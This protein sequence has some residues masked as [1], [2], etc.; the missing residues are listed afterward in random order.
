[1]AT[2]INAA[3][4]SIGMDITKLKEGMGATSSELKK[5]G[6]LLRETEDPANKFR[7]EMELMNRALESGGITMDQYSA[8]QEKL[9]AK[10][11]VVTPAM[12]RAAEA[13]AKLAAE[14][15]AAAEAQRVA[16]EAEKAAMQ[17][18]RDRQA[19]L[20]RGKQLTDS[21]RTATEIHT[22]KI[23]EYKS[24]LKSGLITQETYNRLIRE[25]NSDL[26]K[27]ESQT[28]QLTAAIK[29]QQAET[30]QGPGIS[31]LLSGQL[32]KIAGIAGGAFTVSKIFGDVEKLDSINDKAEQLGIS[33]KDLLVVGRTFEETGGLSFDQA[34]QALSKM[35]VNL[36]NARDKGGDLEI[37]LK[38]V[39]LSSRELAN[40][41]AVTAFQKINQS[42]SQIGNQ[43]DKMQ[44]A[45][46]LFGKAGIDM[47]PA[48]SISAEKFSEMRQHLESVGLL[49]DDLPG[50][51]SKTSDEIQ[52]MNDILLGA[53][54]EIV[55]FFE[56]VFD[57]VKSLT[58]LA[59]NLRRI[60]A[61]ETI[62]NDVAGVNE[63][64][65]KFNTNEIANM[66]K[67][68]REAFENE[69]AKRLADWHRQ[70]KQTE[71]KAAKEKEVQE[72]MDKLV[73]R[74]DAQILKRK[75]EAKQREKEQAAE[76]EKN[77]KL[78]NQ[79]D[80]NLARG[81]E[82]DMGGLESERQ[83]LLGAGNQNVAATIA[84]AIRA[85]TVEAYKA[86]NKQNE[87]RVARQENI[88]KLDEIKTELQKLNTER[89]VILSRI[90]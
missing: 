66:T 90:R 25:A 47:V 51:I 9:A 34:G 67:E 14:Q 44:F 58:D 6:S 84:P 61:G 73:E 70:K 33:F 23:D 52:R 24:A 68:Q 1:M 77:R 54:P 21:V 13:A 15:K 80:S 10:Y 11:G 62:G 81:I 53:A 7:R 19:I 50:K 4:I 88:R 38:R 85:G 28:N 30:R 12:E 87:D 40:M 17:A 39:G 3:N 78:S 59:K 57:S 60:T 31:G 82:R 45:T 49:A 65:I 36:A 2:T 71:E 75:E 20:A 89:A 79:I 63:L 22:Q 16:A 83:R 37:M 27:A 8:A 26:I 42:F 74:M 5:I 86:I 56:P 69:T 76:E 29:K 46:E 32:G 43:A 41:D 72:R 64:G 18:E 55:K 35:Q 48:L